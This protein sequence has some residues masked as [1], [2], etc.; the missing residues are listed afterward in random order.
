MA[1]TNAEKQA[2]WRDS[3]KEAFETLHHSTPK[4]FA[5]AI[6]QLG[7]RRAKKLADALNKRLRA[8]DPKCQVCQG[9]G[10]MRS[11]KIFSACG[12][13]E[14]GGRDMPFPCDCGPLAAELITGAARKAA[15]A[16]SCETGPTCQIDKA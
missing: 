11:V 3:R 10:I 7:V 15:D 5:D 13:P 2:R 16:A 14:F 12:Q 1:L 4:K 6:L 8:I 9:T